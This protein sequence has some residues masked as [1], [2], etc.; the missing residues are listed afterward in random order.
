MSVNPF[1]L[2][3]YE[4]QQW[5][6]ADQQK[7]NEIESL[8]SHLQYIPSLWRKDKESFYIVSKSAKKNN[9]IQITYF[10][11]DMPIFDRVRN[12]NDISDI[13][14]ELHQSEATIE[15]INHIN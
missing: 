3:E 12:I 10:H 7:R 1:L 13:V 2:T 15:T 14:D 9:S 5:I 4:F 6:E 8:L 11:K